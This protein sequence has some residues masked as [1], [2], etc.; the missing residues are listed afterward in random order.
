MKEAPSMPLDL[1]R[2][3]RRRILRTFAIGIPIVMVLCF[4]KWRA[5]DRHA[6]VR[7]I[8]GALPPVEQSEHALMPEE[9][10]AF[11]AR[12]PSL[13][14]APVH[15]YYLFQ[16]KGLDAL[17]E[18]SLSQLQER[19]GGSYSNVVSYR[20]LLE[21]HTGFST[22]TLG[23]ATNI[24]FAAN[25]RE[26]SIWL[27][28]AMRAGDGGFAPADRGISAA[29]HLRLLTSGI[30]ISGRAVA[31]EI[32]MMHVRETI[33]ESIE[34][35]SYSRETARRLI[36]GF[37]LTEDP[38][39]LRPLEEALAIDCA[40]LLQNAEQDI[41]PQLLSEKAR[42]INEGSG[43]APV[44]SNF[45]ISGF[46]AWLMRKL[47][48]NLEETRAHVT[49]LF[50]VLAYNAKQPYSQ[51]GLLTG[52]PPWCRGEKRMPWTRDPVGTFLA[53]GFLRHA[54]YGA[55]IEPNI[56]LETRVARAA[57]ALRIW[58]DGHNGQYPESLSEL[59]EGEEALLRR[60]DV[61]DPFSPSSELL[62]YSRDGENGWR[63]W[64]I[65]LDQE[66]DNGLQDAMTAKDR[67]DRQ[68]SDFIFTSNERLLRAAAMDQEKR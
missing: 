58:K 64:S 5:D 60:E 21:T 37:R 33:M 50:S 46:T 17:D 13:T 25:C 35:Q 7:E 2:R 42:A 14:N 67:K 1:R 54:R 68:K 12:M 36:E 34:A 18:A 28:I 27:M 10:E 30:G 57:V 32:V 38:A 48:A 15:A 61:A 52:L 20:R 65:G 49:A 26:W 40:G 6:W 39:Y 51:M 63:I 62:R 24:R 29:Q 4:F 53:E 8:P 31:L 47:G 59:F 56:R 19:M 22:N 55:A 11:W 16:C 44:Y 9:M 43:A 3:L 23:E 66:D 45:Q 41:Y